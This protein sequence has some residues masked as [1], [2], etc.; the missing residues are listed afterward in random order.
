MNIGDII[1]FYDSTDV[2]SIEIKKVDIGYNNTSYFH[3]A[4][5]IGNNEIIEAI[6]PNVTKTSLSKYANHSYLVC[7]VN[8]IKLSTKATEV[9]KTLVGYP[10]NSLYLYSEDSFYCSSLVHYI[11]KIAIMLH[12]LKNIILNLE[13]N[14]I[15]YQNTGLVYIL[16]II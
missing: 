16:N 15:T 8:N 2:E 13:I 5:Y 7:S 12:T 3:C 6:E 14:L 4:I 1:F 9:A 11:Y 10:Y